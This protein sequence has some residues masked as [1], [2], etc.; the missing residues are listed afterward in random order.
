MIKRQVQVTLPVSDEIADAWQT[1]QDEV[2]MNRARKVAEI[3]IR[4]Q[5]ANA[6]IESVAVNRALILPAERPG[7]M[8]NLWVV[9]DC[10]FE[11]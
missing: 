7:Q 9:F 8:R 3:T 4:E 2:S 6:R 1:Q 11:A 5:C 10:E